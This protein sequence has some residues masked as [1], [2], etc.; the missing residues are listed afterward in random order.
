MV[1]LSVTMASHVLVVKIVR[2]AV[3]QLDIVLIKTLFI[4]IFHSIGSYS[5]ELVHKMASL[6]FKPNI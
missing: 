3:G 2:Y 5:T 1:T 4:L 6:E